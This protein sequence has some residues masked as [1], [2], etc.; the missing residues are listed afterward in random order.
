MLGAYEAVDQLEKLYKYQGATFEIALFDDNLTNQLVTIDTNTNS[1][2]S[3]D[4]KLIN[5]CRVKFTST[6]TLPNPLTTTK[7]YYVVN[8][9]TNEFKIS[10]TKGGSPISLPNAGIGAITVIEQPPNIF[11]SIEIWLK[12]ESDYFGSNR[13][14]ISYVAIDALIDQTNEKVYYPEQITY[15]TPTTGTITYRYIGIIADPNT[16]KQRLRFVQDYQITQ[17]IAKDFTMPFGFT[18]AI[19]LRF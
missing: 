15:F 13:Q 11:D 19:P 10:E 18:P 2:I 16:P 12:F 4:H 8:S 6:N 3:P 1:L 17:S 5:A 14:P 9:S 7:T